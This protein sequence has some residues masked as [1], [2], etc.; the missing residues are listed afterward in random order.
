MELNVNK[1]DVWVYRVM[2]HFNQNQQQVIRCHHEITQNKHWTIEL[3]LR[4]NH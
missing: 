4:E 3:L 1:K 2:S